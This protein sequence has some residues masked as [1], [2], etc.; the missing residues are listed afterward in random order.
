M[1][2]NEVFNS[3]Y[4]WLILLNGHNIGPNA[5]NRSKS[6]VGYA[7][8]DLFL[9]VGGAIQNGHVLFTGRAGNLEID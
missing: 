5:L 2:E 7:M 8:H 4:D 1:T 9:T 3:I 6:Y